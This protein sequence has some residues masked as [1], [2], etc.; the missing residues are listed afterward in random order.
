M[1]SG[2]SSMNFNRNHY[3]QPNHILYHIHAILYLPLFF[4]F[5]LS[6]MYA[7]LHSVQNQ[8]NRHSFPDLYQFFLPHTRL[9]AVPVPPLECS[10]HLSFLFF[11][12]SL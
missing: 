3:H 7:D 5:T 12:P 6:S 8:T 10:Q 2:F 11:F 1:L 9:V 4:G